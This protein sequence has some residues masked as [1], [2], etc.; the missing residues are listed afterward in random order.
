VLRRIDALF[1]LFTFG[2]REE[3]R[4]L[5]IGITHRGHFALRAKVILG[6]TVTVETP[7]HVKR[8][9]EA[10]FDHLVDAT[11]AGFTSYTGLNVSAVLE[12][13]IVGSF[14]DTYPF[15]RLVIYPALSYYT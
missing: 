11:M 5:L 4:A 12:I 3:F 6:L 7:R 9:R 14:V 10:N 13:G 15:D 1:G 8:L 2:S